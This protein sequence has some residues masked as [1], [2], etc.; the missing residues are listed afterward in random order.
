MRRSP[1]LWLSILGACFLLVACDD[2]DNDNNDDDD[3]GEADDD[4]G[5]DD[6]MADDDTGDDDTWPGPVTPP[7]VIVDLVI[8]AEGG[9]QGGDVEVDLTY[10]IELYQGGVLTAECH[11]RFDIDAQ[12]AYGQDQGAEFWPF[13]DETITWFQG[14]E[15]ESTCPPEYAVYKGDLVDWFQWEWHPTSFV[16]CD[17]VGVN[18]ALGET[19]LG[20]DT[21]ADTPGTASDFCSTAAPQLQDALGLGPVEAIWMWPGKSEFLEAMGGIEGFEPQQPG[22]NSVN[23]D[24]YDVWHIGGFLFADAANTDEPIK[25]LSGRYRT[26]PMWLWPW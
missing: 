23:G 4:T 24:T 12:Y 16:S 3:T 2:D 10:T 13:I 5:G 14:E 8:D 20:V 22:E 7:L 25:G 17:S 19:V 11:F 18:A 15:I 1:V 26:V 6:D 9:T 21:I